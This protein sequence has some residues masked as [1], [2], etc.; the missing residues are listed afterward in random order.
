MQVD[1]LD[2]AALL[3]TIAR[4]A[5][6]HGRDPASYMA[7]PGAVSGAGGVLGQVGDG[8]AGPIGSEKNPLYMMQVHPS[9]P[10]TAIPL[11]L[12]YYPLPLLST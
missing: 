3:S 2:Q 8:A 9:F 11:S 7:A 10:P 5:R 4:G 1:R 6:S 12:P